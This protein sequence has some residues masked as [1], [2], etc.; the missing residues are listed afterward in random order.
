MAVET[1]LEHPDI[2]SIRGIQHS[3]DVQQYLGI[4]YAELADGFARGTLKEAYTTPL[5]ATA[6]G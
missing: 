4:Q 6:L 1:I 5:Q 2:G 3:E